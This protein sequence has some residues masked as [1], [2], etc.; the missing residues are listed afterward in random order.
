MVMASARY[1]VYDVASGN[2]SVQAYM[3]A[4]K[5]VRGKSIER[6]HFF[7]Y[8]ILIIDDYKARGRKFRCDEMML[9]CEI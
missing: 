3:Q 7:F 1:D 2:C 8:F 5:Q 6:I 4:C 9:I